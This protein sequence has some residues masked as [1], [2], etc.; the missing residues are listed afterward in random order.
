MFPVNIV[1]F[2]LH[3]C[4]LK[5]VDGSLVRAA[6]LSYVGEAGWEIT[7]VCA[8]APEIVR[9]MFAAGAMPAGLY[10][11]TAMRIE[12]RYLAY[13][14]ELDSDISPLQAGLAFCVDWSR[15]FLGRDALITE[16]ERFEGVQVVSLV[17]CGFDSSDQ[18]RWQANSGQGACWSGVRSGRSSL[19]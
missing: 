12:K 13:G 5:S 9:A 11:Q 3:S 4:L 18:C 14:H 19:A 15:N 7:C 16:K 10:V 1:G 2:V 8:D 17:Y 6:R